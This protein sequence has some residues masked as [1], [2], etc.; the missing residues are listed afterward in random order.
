MMVH[1]EQVLE[2]KPDNIEQL[3]TILQQALE[4]TDNLYKV[5][6]KNAIEIKVGGTYYETH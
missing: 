2:T 5:R 1:D 4:L 3:K 6:C